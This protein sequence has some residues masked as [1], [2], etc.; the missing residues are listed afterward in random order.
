VPKRAVVVFGKSAPRAGLHIPQ[1][2][3]VFAGQ[4]MS[5]MAESRYLGTVFHQ[6]RG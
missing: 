3:W 1:E 2:G 5:V 6:T 4:H